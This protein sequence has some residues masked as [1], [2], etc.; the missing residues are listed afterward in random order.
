MALLKATATITLP[1]GGPSNLFVGLCLSPKYCTS[2]DRQFNYRKFDFSSTSRARESI[3]T[4]F[5]TLNPVVRQNG[6]T[7]ELCETPLGR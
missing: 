6:P 2:H 1:I 4:Q 5:Q 7:A 3:D